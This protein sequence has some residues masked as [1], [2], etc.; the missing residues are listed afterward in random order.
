MSV[1]LF[2]SN[3][4]Q[5]GKTDRAQIVCGTLHVSKEGY[6]IIDDQNFKN[7][8]LTKFDFHCILQIHDLKKK[9]R[10]LFVLFL[11]YNVFKEDI[12]TIE[13]E[14]GREAP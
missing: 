6:K 12:F 8:T 11:L 10:E 14:D 5:D 2:V 1:Y 7:L 13:I 4:R 3:K 9:I